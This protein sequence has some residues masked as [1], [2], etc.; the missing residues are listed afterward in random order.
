M[1]AALSVFERRGQT[2]TATESRECVN[3]VA[4]GTPSQIMNATSNKQRVIYVPDEDFD[5][6]FLHVQPKGHTW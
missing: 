3:P 4:V 2:V 5:S 6:D 1:A